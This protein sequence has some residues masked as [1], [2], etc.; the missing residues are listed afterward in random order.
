MVAT[1]GVLHE[2]V[3][4]HRP[5]ER[6]DLGIGRTWLVMLRNVLESRHLIWQLFKRDFF[7]AYKKSFVGVTWRFAAPLAAIISWVFLKEMKVLDPG[8]VGMSY[9][10]YVLTG[11]MAWGLF[12][13]FYASAHSTLSAGSGLVM[14]VN[15]PHEC[16][17]FKQLATQMAN[18][19]FTLTTTVVVLLAYGQAPNW[20]IVFLPAAVLPMLFLG[21]SF[22]LVFSMVSIVAMDVDRIADYALRLLM[23]A[24]PVIYGPAKIAARLAELTGDRVVGRLALEIVE[25]WNPLTYFVCSA[26]NLI[27]RGELYEPRGYFIASAVSLVLFLL[28]WRLFYVSENRVIERMI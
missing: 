26:R 8:D 1:R 19:T 17:F 13:G 12:R 27:V 18:F 23:F 3:V 7:A 4:F 6:H 24:T 22:G 16:L 28:S 25:K 15:Y 21:A 9:V 20:K 11:N 14:Q 2:R 5:N 10:P